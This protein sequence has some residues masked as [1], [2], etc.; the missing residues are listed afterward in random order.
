M[1]DCV[2]VLAFVIQ[3][4]CWSVWLER[5]LERVYVAL[6]SCTNLE[7]PLSCALKYAISNHV[8]ICM[9]YIYIYMYICADREREMPK[10]NICVYVM[11][12][13]ICIYMCIYVRFCLF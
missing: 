3:P 13:Y 6:E 4:I 5:M 2:C 8:C 7:E 10:C 12:I 11:Y 9:I 1:R